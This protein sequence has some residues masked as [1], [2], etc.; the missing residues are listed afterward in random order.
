MDASVK[1]INKLQR[2]KLFVDYYRQWGSIGEAC[3]HAGIK[4]RRTVE[5]WLEC[6]HHFADIFDELKA[7]RVDQIAT[8][9][10]R[11]ACGELGLTGPQVTSAI[12]LL[13][14]LDPAQFAEKHHHELTGKD[15]GPVSIE[16][17]MVE[18]REEDGDAPG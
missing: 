4:R 10:Y 17:V 15:G 7:N 1:K 5:G 6:D 3:R 13:K 18:P 12:F 8:R 14:V 16:Y 11:A 9:L 2:Q